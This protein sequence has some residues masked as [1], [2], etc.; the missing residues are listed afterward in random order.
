MVALNIHTKKLQTR[1]ATVLAESSPRLAIT[2]SPIISAVFHLMPDIHTPVVNAP[3]YQ[4][5]TCYYVFWG[6]Y[7]V[8]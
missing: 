1:V 3:S 8:T 6:D 2:F 7:V 5:V 4:Y